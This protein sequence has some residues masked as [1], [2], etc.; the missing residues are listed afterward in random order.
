VN[1]WYTWLRQ[2]QHIRLLGSRAKTDQNLTEKPK[3]NLSASKKKLSLMTY[4]IVVL[5]SKRKVM[6]FLRKNFYNSL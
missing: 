2:D 4:E 1:G 3:V 6:I 5:T